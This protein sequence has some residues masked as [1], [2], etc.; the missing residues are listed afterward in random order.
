MTN[1]QYIAAKPVVASVCGEYIV[2]IAVFDSADAFR[3]LRLLPRVFRAGRPGFERL[4][5]LK[6][7]ID[8]T[9][10]FSVMM[11]RKGNRNAKSF[12]KQSSPI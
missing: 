5:I 7:A 4:D 2:P 3:A 6:F 10:V 9:G 12:G 8:S 11:P 1:N